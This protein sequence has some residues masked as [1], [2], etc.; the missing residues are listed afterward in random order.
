MAR[1]TGLLTMPLR[2]IQSFCNL[3]AVTATVFCLQSIFLS[4]WDS[5]L[6]TDVGLRAFL[7]ISGPG[8][9]LQLIHLPLDCTIILI[10]SAGWSFDGWLTLANRDPQDLKK[11]K[12][13]TIMKFNK[14]YTHSACCWKRRTELQRVALYKTKRT[15]WSSVKNE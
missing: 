2:L 4:S 1:Q 6:F 12:N 5:I 15:R 13:K 10:F 7:L 8:E 9:S 11:F 3:P 14:N